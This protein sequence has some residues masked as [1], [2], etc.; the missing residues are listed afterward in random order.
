MGF[1]KYN[2]GK[3]IPKNM[4]FGLAGKQN[5]TSVMIHYFQNGK[6]QMAGIKIPRGGSF[7]KAFNSS[8]IIARIRKQDEYHALV[9]IGY[10]RNRF[11]NVK[12]ELGLLSSDFSPNARICQPNLNAIDSMDIV[13][14][15]IFPNNFH[16]CFSH[17]YKKFCDQMFDGI[18]QVNCYKDLMNAYFRH[19]SARFLPPPSTPEYA[20]WL[21]KTLNFNK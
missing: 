10:N 6:Y 15:F 8:P 16:N 14:V 7:F 2:I 12:D 1:P 19:R 20:I 13:G 21:G 4:S 11:P 9:S 5:G 3:V 18:Q 17:V